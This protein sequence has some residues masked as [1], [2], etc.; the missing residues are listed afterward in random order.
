MNFRIRTTCTFVVSLSVVLLIP[1]AELSVKHYHYQRN[2]KFTFFGSLTNDWDVLFSGEGNT[3][4][5]AVKQCA[6]FCRRDTRCIGMELCKITED[7][8]RC[9]VCCKTKLKEQEIPMNTTDRCRYM[10]MVRI[11]VLFTNYYNLMLLLNRK[12][13]N[14]T[15][16]FIYETYDRHFSLVLYLSFF[17]I[18]MYKA[19]RTS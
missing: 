4:H 15:Q 10:A 9:R 13:Y 5:N 2:F 8:I 6:E 14:L 17:Y 19:R 12:K 1:K 16:V 18:C 7:R 3:F 11:N